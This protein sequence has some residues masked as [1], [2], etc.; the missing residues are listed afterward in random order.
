M[1]PTFPSSQIVSLRLQSFHG[2]L[3]CRISAVS[4]RVPCH[5]ADREIVIVASRTSPHLRRLIVYRQSVVDDP[6]RAA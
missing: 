1:G 2:R 6:P 3:L 4:R 5:K